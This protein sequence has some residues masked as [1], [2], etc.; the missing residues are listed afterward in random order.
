M[1]RRSTSCVHFPL[2]TPIVPIFITPQRKL[3]LSHGHCVTFLKG[4]AVNWHF[5]AGLPIFSQ[6]SHSYPSKSTV[7]DAQ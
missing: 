7:K 1:T 4:L 2:P 3:T 6:R 5:R